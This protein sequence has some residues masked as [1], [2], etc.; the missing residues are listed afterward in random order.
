MLRNHFKIAV[1]NLIRNKAHSFINITGLSA[2]MAITML[3]GLWIWDEL[4]FDKYHQHY[5]TI[6]QVMQ[7]QTINDEVRSQVQVPIPLGEELRMT[8]GSEFKR[9]VMSSMPESHILAAGENKFVRTGNYMEAGAPDLFALKML[10]GS[11]NGL[12]DPASILLS[13]S[14]ATLLFGNTNPINKTLK[15]DDEQSLTVTGVYEDL[16]RNTTLNNLLFIAPWKLMP[17][18][19]KNL[20]NWGNNG[21]QIY[22]QMADN[23]DVDKASLKIRDAKSNKDNS[24][25]R[26]KPVIFLHPMSR[27]HLYSEFKNGV[28]TGGRIQYVWLFGIIGVFVLLLACINFMNLSTARSE[29]RAKEVG[30]RKAIGS[31]RTQLIYQFF[32]ESLLVA[33][34]SFIFSLLLVFLLLPFFN[35]VAGKKLSILWVNPVFWITGIGFSLLSGIIAGSYP[36]LYL[37]AFQP[38]KVLKGT[39]KA[40]RLA[41]V[42]RRVL[43]V[44]QFAVSVILIIGTIVVFRQIQ[45]ARSRPVGYSRDG[46]INIKNLTPDIYQHF[47]AFRED[48][49]RTGA[50]TEA[51]E[52]STPVTESN[53][54]QS[55]FDWQGREA[56]GNNQGFATVGVSKEYGKTIGWHFVDGR[57]YQ[58]GPEGADALAFVVNE[59]AAKLMG[60]KNPVGETVRW[61]GYTF[62][63]IGVT[64]DMV[65]QSPFDPALPTIFYMAP[66]KVNVLNIRINPAANAADAL[67]KIEQV[68]KQYNPGQPFEYKFA[69]DEYAR[70]FD[71]E[72]RV[73]KLTTF[74]SILAIF[75][76]CLGLFGMASFMAEQRTKEIGIRK[77]LGASV[78]NVWGLLSREFVMLVLAALLIATPLAYYFMH[79]WLQRYQYRADLSWWIFFAAAAGALLITILT[80][81][82]QSIKAALMDPV[83]SLKTE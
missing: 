75:I 65:M 83:R 50:V 73:G 59:S 29:K 76:S 9:V 69:S 27:W 33:F 19:E 31:L 15:F 48:L 57:D 68:Y 64:K 30:I 79:I 82:Y 3:I 77:V 6:A 67:K 62:H 78:L 63:I 80:V 40:G 11:G 49:I 25:E 38:V 42:P 60:F 56:N 47:A 45:F 35:E 43:V 58:T 51:A 8:Y 7:S 12:N 44:L 20:Q 1:R 41:A 23:V 2:G 74:F 52:S 70:K 34:I 28:N 24:E 71:V 36:A 14:T 16:P 55:N 72:E 61:M 10:K 22:V 39:F 46:L 21:W 66:W 5:N 17:K 54:E 37:S 18:L 81:S 13:Q 4:S 26:F 53:N 32:S